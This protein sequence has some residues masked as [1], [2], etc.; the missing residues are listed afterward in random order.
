MAAKMVAGDRGLALWFG[1]GETVGVGVAVARF[2]M[3]VLDK[4]G[5]GPERRAGEAGEK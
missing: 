5:P 2:V 1:R 3:R 4:E